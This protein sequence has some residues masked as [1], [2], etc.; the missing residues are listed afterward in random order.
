MGAWGTEWNAND[1]GMDY[2]G[3]ELFNEEFFKIVEAGLDSQ[4]FEK[5]RVSAHTLVV[6]ENH[7]YTLPLEDGA[8]LLHK[9]KKALEGILMSEW[10]DEWNDPSEIRNEIRKELKAVQDVLGDPDKWWNREG[11]QQSKDAVNEIVANL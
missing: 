3:G 7:L 2:L 9:A 6:L 4:Y 1:T 10:T 5:V 11:L 8:I